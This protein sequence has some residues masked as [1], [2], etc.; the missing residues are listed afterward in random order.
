MNIIFGVGHKR[1][2]DDI[3]P[4]CII[5][6]TV[7][8]HVENNDTISTYFSN[9]A[10]ENESQIVGSFSLAEG[11]VENIFRVGSKWESNREKLGTIA[12]STATINH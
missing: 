5:N 2:W 11:G 7:P 1:S 6:F 8:A 3:Y 10:L 12:T 9:K 4:V